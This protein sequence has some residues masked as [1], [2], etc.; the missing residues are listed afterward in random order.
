MPVPDV[1]LRLLL[2]LVASTGIPV[3]TVAQVAGAPRLVVLPS[4]LPYSVQ[5]HAGVLQASPGHRLVGVLLILRDSGDLRFG[6]DVAAL[7]T[8]SGQRLLPIAFSPD[9][10]AQQSIPF[11]AL[12]P[13]QMLGGYGEH[14]EGYVLVRRSDAITITRR[15]PRGT[16][17][18]LLYEVSAEHARLTF[19]FLDQPAVTL[20]VPHSAARP[21]N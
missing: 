10:L 11:E 2:T 12:N 3:T 9:S 4:Q 6:R 18:I 15:G 5:S 17:F 13:G 16:P 1:A 8:T 20:D 14:G 21:P 7:S 19:T